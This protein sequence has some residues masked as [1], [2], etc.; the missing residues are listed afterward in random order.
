MVLL[1]VVLPEV[2][3]EFRSLGRVFCVFELLVVVQLVDV[4]EMS[5]LSMV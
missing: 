1:D 5:E 2:D 3:S 4:L